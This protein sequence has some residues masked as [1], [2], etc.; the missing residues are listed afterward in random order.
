MWRLVAH[1][2]EFEIAARSPSLVVMTEVTCLVLVTSVLLNWLLRSM[3]ATTLPC[4]V[5][6]IIS[7][8]GETRKF[9]LGIFFGWIKFGQELADLVGRP[10]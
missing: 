1:R 4:P 8:G 2:K 7:Y 3:G 5:T 10:E 6:F 9:T